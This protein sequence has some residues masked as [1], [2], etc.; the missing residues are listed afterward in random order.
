MKYTIRTI[1]TF[2]L[3]SVGLL[4]GAR[5]AENIPGPKATTLDNGQK[6]VV[7]E[8]H[9]ADLV[10]IDVWVGAGTINETDDTSG[11]SHFI[12]HCLFRS[13]DKRGPGQVDME[14]ESLGSSLEARTSRDWAHFYTVV[15]RRYLDKALDVIADVVTHPKFL[16]SDIDHERAVIL[17]E[18]ARKE[19]DPFKV[20]N[21][22]LYAAGYKTHPYRLP[23]EGTRDS[24][25]KMTREKIVDYYGRLYVPENITVVLAGDV[26]ADDGTQAVR[27]AFEGFAKKPLAAPQIPVEPTRTA[28]SRIVVKKNTKLD[29]VGIAFPAPSVKDRPDVFAMDVLL[30]HLGIGYQSWL[31]T[32]LKDTRKLAVDVSSDYLTQR[33][34]SLV[35]LAAA[36]EPVK[37]DAVEAAILAKTAALR[38]KPIRD[39][40]LE[41]A[42]RWVLG[43]NAFDI[44]TFSGRATNIG[45][46]YTIG[47]PELAESYGKSIEAVTA[48]DVMAAAKKYLDPDKSVIVVLGP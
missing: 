23:V 16:Q 32:D 35:V 33:D 42:K 39:F 19:S 43:T 41:R 4:T 20:L 34:P 46:Y 25:Q 14:I 9:S 10:A 7:A 28:K 15:A 27:K 11:V 40:E 44:E 30:A 47:A 21:D 5:A 26:T 6:V 22:K 17:D 2:A 48:D 37:S 24:V 12:E 8:D 18:I 1:I 29:Y 38:E 3:L 13:T 31:S 45:F 36:C